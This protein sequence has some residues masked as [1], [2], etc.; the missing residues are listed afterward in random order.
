MSFYNYF[1]VISAHAHA[2]LNY[3]Q[4]LCGRKAAIYLG[5][6]ILNIQHYIHL[7]I[8]VVNALS[9]HFHFEKY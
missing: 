5:S 7:G 1:K 6:N 9:L 8:T 2:T 3:V 4:Q